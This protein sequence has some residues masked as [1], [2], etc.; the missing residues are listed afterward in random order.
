ML[1]EM[2]RYGPAIRPEVT[3]LWGFWGGDASFITDNAKAAWDMTA[4]TPVMDFIGGRPC[5]ALTNSGSTATDGAQAQATQGFIQPQ[6]GKEIQICGS[7]RMTTNTQE[8][9]LGL[10][11]IDTSVIA[12]APT[13]LILLEKLTTVTAP[14][15]KARKATGTVETWTLGKTLLVDTW[16]D[17]SMRLV[18]DASTAGKGNAQVY[19]G[20]SLNA[21]GTMEVLFNGTIATQFPDTVDL[22][23]TLAWRAG[24]AANVSGYIGHFGVRVAA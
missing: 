11:I 5:L 7:F 14:S 19:I 24:S 1:E 18:R 8:F 21:K 6:A 13:D 20:E 23:P 22:A 16:Y 9:S 3:A 15:L 10:A 2:F 17:F 12:S 4:V